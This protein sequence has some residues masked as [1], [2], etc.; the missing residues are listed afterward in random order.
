MGQP[1]WPQQTSLL[2]AAPSFTA[3]R[4]LPPAPLAPK[5]RRVCTTGLC[6]PVRAAIRREASEK[7]S[8]R[9]LG[10]GYTREQLDPLQKKAPPVGVFEALESHTAKLQ[11][12]GLS[13]EDPV[14]VAVSGSVDLGLD[15]LVSLR[16]GL[17]SRGFTSADLVKVASSHAGSHALAA[18]L[19]YGPALRERGFTA[20]NVVKIAS[21]G[22]SFRSLATVHQ[23]ATALRQL[24]LTVADIATIAGRRG[25][26]SGRGSR[27]PTRPNAPR[28]R[29]FYVWGSQHSRQLWP[30]SCH[31]GRAPARPSAAQARLCRGRSSE[32]GRQCCWR[33]NSR[34]SVLVGR[35]ASKSGFFF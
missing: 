17:L 35:S 16:Q 33:Q 1:D 3:K 27:G 4:S 26:T 15:A 21:H 20:S 5:K 28:T 29:L 14:R 30:F 2:S 7:S 25:R 23:G 34:S 18:V 10:L 6:T 9:L 11:A 13:T 8:G 12:L 32:N 19:R 22:A 31:G 24:E